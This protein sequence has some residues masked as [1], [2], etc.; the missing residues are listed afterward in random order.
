M[1]HVLTALDTIVTVS[2]VTVF[3]CEVLFIFSLLFISVFF[4]VASNIAR[5]VDDVFAA[6]DAFTFSFFVKPFLVT[7]CV[8]GRVC[9]TIDC[10]APCCFLLCRYSKAY[11]KC[12]NSKKFSLNAVGN[13]NNGSDGQRGIRPSLHFYRALGPPCIFIA[14]QHTDARY[15]YSNSV[16]PSVCPSVS[17]WHAGIVWKRL[18][19]I[20]IVFFHH[21]VAQSFCLPASHIFMK[22]RDSLQ[23][24]GGV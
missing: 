19:I 7:A 14:R 5:V 10:S 17:P 23:V 15:W 8:L 2:G 18:N 11:H 3:V 13:K 20:V 22:S 4:F 9:Q 1:T 21:T 24:T 16:C 12:T 6:G